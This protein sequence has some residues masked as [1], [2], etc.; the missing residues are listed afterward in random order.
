MGKKSS[1]A[2]SAP[3]PTETARAES[4]YNRLDTYGPDG[5]GIRHGYTN[6]AGEFVQ[7]VA[8]SGRQSAQ[9]TFESDTQR[10]IRELLEPASVGL[11]S[12]IITDNVD[13][14]PD[15]ARV[16]DRGT[17]A[18]DIFDRSFSLMSPA[19]E[20]ANSRLLNNLQAR[21]IPIGGEAFNEAYGEQQTRT[22]DTLSR[23]A[24]DAN[25]A[26]GQEQSRQFSL[27]QAERSGAISEIMAAM[28]GGY[29]PPTNIPSGS[30][31]P[32]NYS[33]MVSDQYNA[34]MNQY[35]QS[36]QNK[37]GA[38]GA[39]GSLGSALIK[40][41]MESKHVE[42]GLKNE[43]A[44]NVVSAMPLF[45]WRYLPEHAPDGDQKRHIGPMA[46]HFKDLTGLGDGKTISVIDYLGLLSGA[47][48]N[49]LQRLEILEY[50]MAGGEVN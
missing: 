47:L 26:A 9:Q 49:A 42:A 15:A 17:V 7:G 29:N 2:P 10:Q 48:Q 14:L 43:W 32:I 4:Q 39:V 20:K 25:V 38:A 41:T 3:N 27:D 33:G 19:I 16:Q 23:L 34:Q 8:P 6:G 24:Q 46:E 28:G 22:Q 45:V 11:T 31:Q 35:N 5:A 36:Q 50:R 40:S 18:Q 13:G 30:A 12:R 1:K 21:G 44:G 37:M